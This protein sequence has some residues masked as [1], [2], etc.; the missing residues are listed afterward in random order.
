MKRPLPPGSIATGQPLENCVM[1][2][3]RRDV[4]RL[5]ALVAS[6]RVPQSA[7]L[8]EAIEDLL[9]KYERRRS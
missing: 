2:L 4:T 9:E 8:R 1:R 3:P 6:T 7:Y 5:K